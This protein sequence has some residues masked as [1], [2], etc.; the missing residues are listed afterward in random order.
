[1]DGRCRLSHALEDCPQTQAQEKCL[2]LKAHAFK[3]LSSGLSAEVEDM[4]GIESS[5]L[6]NANLLSKALKEIYGSN[7]IGKSSMKIASTNISVS[8]EHIDQEQVVQSKIQEEEAKSTNLR[9]SDSPISLTGCSGFGRTEASS[10]NEDDF[11]SS[12]SDDDDD[13]INDDEDD[14]Q[15][16]LEEFHKLISKHMK[17]QKRYGDLL[18]SHEKLIDSYALLEATH[19]V[20]L[21]MV[22]SSEPH[23]LLIYLVLTLVALKQSHHAMSMYL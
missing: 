18:C 1:V 5:F 12:S 15:V 2:Y 22:K 13:S 17:L 14:D 20:M 11:S 7:N 4:I 23:T 6:E 3:A 16:L 9:K 19:E 10:L 8:K 21:T